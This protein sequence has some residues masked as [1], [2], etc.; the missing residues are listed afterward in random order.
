M[1]F[2]MVDLSAFYFDML[3]DRLYTSAP[4]SPGR[5]SAQ[6]ALWRICEALVRLLAPIMSFTCDEVWGYLPKM[7]GRPDSVHVAL[8]P[9]REE[10]LGSAQVAEDPKQLEDWTTLLAVRSRC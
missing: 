9:S 1:N 3:K 8:F 6:T 5:R 2:C 10:I 4:N 7:H